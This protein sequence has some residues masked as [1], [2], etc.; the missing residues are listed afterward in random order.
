MKILRSDF[1][2]I[3][4]YCLGEIC[5]GDPT[6]VPNVNLGDLPTGLQMESQKQ[7]NSPNRPLVTHSIHAGYGGGSICPKTGQI[8]Y[9]NLLKLSGNKWL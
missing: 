9:G 7:T 3:P 2:Q 4:R 1:E 6:T 5:W 8:V